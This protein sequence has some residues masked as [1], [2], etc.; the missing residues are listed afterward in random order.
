VQGI[1]DF[2]G[3]GSSFVDVFMDDNTVSPTLVESCIET[4]SDPKQKA[5]SSSLLEFGDLMH[6]APDG[7]NDEEQPVPKEDNPSSNPSSSKRQVIESRMKP[8][9][10]YATSVE[11]EPKLDE[12]L[13]LIG[14]GVRKKSIVSVYAVSMYS[15]PA[16]IEALSPYT[17]DKSQKKDASSALH[18]AA[19]TFDS[20]TP[21]TVFVLEMVYSASAEK[22]ASAIADS[23]KPRY[24]GSPSDVGTLESLI[25]EG[26]N[27]KGGQASKGTIF[28]FDCSNGGVGVSVDG[29]HQGMA[30]FEGMGGAF[31]DV[32]MDENAVSPTL[33]GSC[34]DTW[35]AVALR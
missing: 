18:V 22:I 32:F 34:L 29:K 28:R 20:F 7:S 3:M 1:A 25:I 33:I 6:A 14:V 19:R 4:W 30:S 9:K 10:D 11:F 35:T 12:G 13:Y 31:V 5:I 15:S 24:D 21:T 27:I 23:V 16:V 8:L 17:Q 2:D 26:V